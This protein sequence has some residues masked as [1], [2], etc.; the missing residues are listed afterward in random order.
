MGHLAEIG[1]FGDVAA[2]DDDAV[3]SYFLKTD[4][5][6]E[7]ESGSKFVVI[8]RKGSGKTALATYFSEPRGSYVT[9]SP[10]LRDYPWA[11][12][13]RRQNL[14]ASEIESYVSA[15]RYLIAIKANASILDQK[16]MK[17]QTD[18]QRLARDFLTENYG[19]INPNLG[20]ILQPKKLNIK[21]ISIAPKI[22]GNS[23][24]NVNLENEDGGFSPEVDLLTDILI[25]NA[26]T[27]ASQ[28]NTSR[29]FIHFDELDQGMSSLDDTRRLMITGLILAIRS[30]RTRRAKESRI[31]PVA[32]LRTDIWDKL[33]FSDKNKISQSSAVMLE[34]DSDTLLEMINERIKAKLGVVDTVGSI[35]TMRQ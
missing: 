1:T 13:A 7:L 10:S 5:V 33:R 17:K 28:S 21:S 19:G 25:E 26:N 20:D 29:I 34:W 31:L 23:L 12:H 2:E 27:L 24:G 18:A 16:G 22:L 15:W 4:A 11:L 14:G 6:D 8:G 9:I 3:L 30:L 32:Y 35:S